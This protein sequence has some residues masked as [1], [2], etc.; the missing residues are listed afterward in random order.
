MSQ[1]AASTTGATFW[2]SQVQITGDHSI[3]KINHLG[4]YFPRW[5]QKNE[6]RRLAQLLRSDKFCFCDR[7]IKWIGKSELTK[8]QNQGGQI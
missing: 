2:A 5:G 1:V 6:S 7:F 8:I 3:K 4:G